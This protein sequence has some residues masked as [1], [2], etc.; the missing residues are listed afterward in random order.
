MGEQLREA[1]R[2][3]LERMY[4][5]SVD[6]ADVAREYVPNHLKNEN[7]PRFLEWCEYT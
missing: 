2:E 4:C 5:Q 1:Y 7:D 3:Y 6:M